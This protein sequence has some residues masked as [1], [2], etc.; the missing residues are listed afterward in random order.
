M[1]RKYRRV[2]RMQC[3]NLECMWDTMSTLDGRCFCGTRMILM[4]DNDAIDDIARGQ[5]TP[6]EL[7]VWMRMVCVELAKQEGR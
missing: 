6:Q 2:T 5:W 1:M 4:P 7:D 3:T